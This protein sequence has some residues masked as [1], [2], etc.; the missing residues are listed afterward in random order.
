[1]LLGPA[2]AVQESTAMVLLVIT[3]AS[4]SRVI[5]KEVALRDVKWVDFTGLSG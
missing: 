5:N 3:R 4:H 2:A 1:M